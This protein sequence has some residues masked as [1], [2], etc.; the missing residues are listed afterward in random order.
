MFSLPAAMG[1]LM[2]SYLFVA[3]G[4]QKLSDPNGFRTALQDYDILPPGAATAAARLL[5]L[6]ELAAGIALLV[7]A[8]SKPGLFAGA[9]LLTI[10]TGAIAINIHRGNTGLNCGCAG[11]GQEQTIS[12][13]LLFRNAALIA[14]AVFSASHIQAA[15]LSL[16]DWAI[17]FA[18]AI[19]AVLFYHLFNQLVA[20]H[21]ALR[22]VSHHG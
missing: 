11:P 9:G 15:T 4:W 1:S 3:G 17:A 14:L 10:Y 12:V 16:P 13:W 8:L 19:F 22:R 20:N 2:L 5:P 21:K 18:G 6:V 7:P